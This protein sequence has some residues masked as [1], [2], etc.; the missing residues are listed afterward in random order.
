MPGMGQGMPGPKGPPGPPGPPGLPGNPGIP[1]SPGSSGAAGQ[2][3]IC[4]KYCAADGGV[5]FEDGT[6][7][8]AKR[9]ILYSISPLN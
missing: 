1:G 4:P 2:R 5:F 8:R 9:A 7:R 6:R 3:G